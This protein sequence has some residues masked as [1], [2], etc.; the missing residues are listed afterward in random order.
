MLGAQ[1]LSLPTELLMSFHF[2]KRAAEPQLRPMSREAVQSC[3]AVA[4]HFCREMSP[5]SFRG[6]ERG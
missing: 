6:E 2:L 5:S 3:R 4:P 1:A